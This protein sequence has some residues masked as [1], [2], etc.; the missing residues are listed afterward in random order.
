LRSAPFTLALIA[1]FL[2]VG[3]LIAFWGFIFPVNQ[4]TQ[5]WTML[6][7]N[8]EALRAQWEYSHAVRALLY[9][10]GL[11]ITPLDHDQRTGAV[12]RETGGAID[13][14]DSPTES[15]KENSEVLTNSNPPGLQ[16]KRSLPPSQL[17]GPRQFSADWAGGGV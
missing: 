6:P 17:Q 16:N 10:L 15:L 11:R 5:N 4:A 8:W 14:A 3:E 9:V 12:T 13:G 1:L 7:D 2:L